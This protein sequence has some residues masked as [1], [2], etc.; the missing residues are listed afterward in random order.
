MQIKGAV[1]L[2]TG[3][4]GGI[5]AAIARQLSV[6]GAAAIGIGDLDLAAAE[7]IAEEL[8][9]SGVRT[10]AAKVDVG[11]AAQVSAFIDRA[12]KALGPVDLMC[13]NAGIFTASA[14]EASD[15]DWERSWRV[16]VMSNVYVAREIVP[17]MIARGG[18]YLMITCSAAG[19]LANRNA[20][21]MATKHAAVAYAEWLAIQY[22]SRGLIVSALCPLGVQTSMLARLVAEDGAAAAGVLAGGDVLAPERVAEIVIQGIAAQRFLI[23]PHEAVRERIVSKAS[24]RDL[25][26][27]GMEQQ[28]GIV[29]S[30]H[31]AAH[32]RTQRWRGPERKQL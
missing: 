26:I 12:E 9:K 16:N 5:G 25:W 30:T 32:D 29:S 17:R 10:F 21:Y 31:V 19:L 8:G 1:A 23:L 20:P 28:Y 11:D 3:G 22:R 13:S 7:R 24:D 18:G 14:E 27:G 2:I 15:Q 6:A 4:A